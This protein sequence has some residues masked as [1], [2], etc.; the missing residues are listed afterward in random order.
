LAE[1]SLVFSSK[2]S[3]PP[4][5]PDEAGATAVEGTSDAKPI[6]LSDVTEL[7]FETLVRYFYKR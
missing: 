1:N 6:H 5:G 2:F 4:C 3:L 7:E